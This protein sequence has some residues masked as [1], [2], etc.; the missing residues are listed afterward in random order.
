LI[1][2]AIKISCQKVEFHSAVA[3]FELV[4]F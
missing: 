3:R 2:D 4:N 1:S